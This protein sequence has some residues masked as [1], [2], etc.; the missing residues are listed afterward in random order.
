MLA[1]EIPHFQNH[2]G[3]SRSKYFQH[4][5]FAI[6][7]HSNLVTTYHPQTCGEAVL[8]VKCLW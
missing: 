5:S 2:V 6:E 8:V 4:T 7:N 3:V 1:A